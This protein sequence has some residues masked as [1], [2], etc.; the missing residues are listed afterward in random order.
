MIVGPD[1]IWLHFPKC[2]GTSVEVALREVFAHDRRVAFDPIDLTNVIWHHS[3]REREKHDPSF[4]PAGKR[5]ISCFRRLPTWLLSRVHFEA[6]RSPKLV[7]SRQEFLSGKFYEANGF[8][9]SADRVL[10]RYTSPQ[11]D[12]WIRV[13]NLNEDFA[14]AFGVANFIV[15]KINEAKVSFI[16]KESFWFTPDD[17]RRIYESNP[18]WAEMEFRVYG[19]L[20]EL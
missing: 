10:A 6:W 9:N 19:N 13:E 2:G 12:Q 3:I 11:I 1:F 20:M 17:L 16:K 18:K 14:K 15:K 4:N 8:L 7:P 5:V